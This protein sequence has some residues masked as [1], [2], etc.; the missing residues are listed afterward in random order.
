MIYD[1]I[2]TCWCLHAQARGAPAPPPLPVGPGCLANGLVVPC[3]GS[4]FFFPWASLIR[5]GASAC[6]CK[7]WSTENIGEALK[8]ENLILGSRSLYSKGNFRI[9]ILA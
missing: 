6:A 3:C 5:M 7:L 1:Q 9:L 4:I 2:I 8:K